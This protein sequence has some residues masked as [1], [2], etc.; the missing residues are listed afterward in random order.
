MSFEAL[1]GVASNTHGRFD[2]LIGFPGIARPLERA[3]QPRVAEVADRVP[4]WRRTPRV[5]LI[6]VLPEGHDLGASELAGR[7]PPR[8]E[9]SEVIIACAGRPANLHAIQRAVSDAQFLFAPTGTCAGDLRELA[10]HLA[11]GDIVTLVSG[12]PGLGGSADERPQD[13]AEDSR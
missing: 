8:G 13:V 12:K 11:S 4:T 2:D 7:L 5:S 3:G 9:G 6:V 10:M 1:D